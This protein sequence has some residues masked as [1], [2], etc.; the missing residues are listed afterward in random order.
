[1]EDLDLSMEVL[2]LSMEDLDLSMEVLDLSTEDLVQST[3]GQFMVQVCL[4]PCKTCRLT[5]V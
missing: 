3:E 1:M 2:V 5:A 4:R